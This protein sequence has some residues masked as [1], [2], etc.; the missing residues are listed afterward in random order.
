MEIMNREI[1]KRV[2]RN[3]V[4]FGWF[5]FSTPLLALI[6]FGRYLSKANLALCKFYLNNVL[7]GRER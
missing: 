2:E 5:I 3:I 4:Q 7:R 6:F 1:M